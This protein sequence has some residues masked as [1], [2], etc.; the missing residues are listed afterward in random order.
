VLPDAAPRVVGAFFWA[1]PEEV[2]VY[3]QN[4]SVLVEN[5]SR[6]H[7]EPRQYRLREIWGVWAAAA[8]PMAALAW[9]VAPALAHILDGPTGWPRALLACMTAGLVWQGVLVLALVRR[10]TGSL[11]WPTV[12]DAL[13]L[14]RPVSPRTGRVGG[15]VWWVLLPAVLVVGLAQLLPSIPGPA[16]RDLGAFLRSAIGQQ[17]LS[18]NWPWFALIVVMA[19]FNTVLG[20]ELLFRGLLLPRM[21]GAFGRA[22]WL[23]NGLLFAVYHLHMP[24]V[25]PKALLDTLALAYPTRRYRSAWLGIL[26]HSVQSLLIVS[27]SLAAVLR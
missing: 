4:T 14:G 7:A 25:I 18:G 2:T 10:E 23:A 13:W 17:F 15:R 26:V 21:R 20:E 16:E 24:W 3:Q 11:R 8:L 6:D 9:L 22:D 12:R 19:V 5:S 27:A 1:K